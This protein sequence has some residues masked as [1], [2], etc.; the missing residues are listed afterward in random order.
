MMKHNLDGEK[1]LFYS[2]LLKMRVGKHFRTAD[3]PYRILW[4]TTI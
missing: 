1:L 2:E 3:I 4:E